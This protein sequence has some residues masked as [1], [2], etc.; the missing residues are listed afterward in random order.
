[1][2]DTWMPWNALISIVLIF[3]ALAFGLYLWPELDDRFNAIT[4]R[5]DTI[6]GS[7]AGLKMGPPGPKGEQGPAGPKGERGESSAEVIAGLK[8]IEARF[9]DLND[10]IAVLERRLSSA[11]GDNVLASE[12]SQQ[13]DNVLLEIASCRKGEAKI[14]C[15]IFVTSLKGNQ[16][17]QFQ[18]GAK[19]FDNS[20]NV[21]SWLGFQGQGEAGMESGGGISRNFAEGVRGRSLVFYESETDQP[22][23][24]IALLQ[25]VFDGKSGRHTLAF[26]NVPVVGN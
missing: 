9:A 12:L 26:K 3:G 20:G 18:S 10:R 2:S 16:Q 15:P 14:S 17:I 1:M 24:S 22:S 6:E 8:A 25:V 19:A 5:I 13:A 23:K 7:L 21:Y 11:Q 4:N